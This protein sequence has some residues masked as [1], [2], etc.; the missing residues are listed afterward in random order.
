MRPHNRPQ[1]W[2]C[3][4]RV[5]VS[6]G[7]CRQPSPHNSRTPVDDNGGGATRGRVR[8][9]L[10][11][12]HPIAGDGLP[13]GGRRPVR[14]SPR[15]ARCARLR[16]AD[17]RDAGSAPGPPRADGRCPASSLPGRR[18]LFL[19][20]F[21]RTL[22]QI[23]QTLPQIVHNVRELID[24]GIE[25]ASLKQAID[26]ST[27][28][29]RV[30]VYIF[31]M[32]AEIERDMIGH[33]VK[34]GLAATRAKGTVLGRPPKAVDL[35]ALAGLLAARRPGA[36]RPRGCGPRAGSPR[37]SGTWRGRRSAR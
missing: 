26:L 9:L 24:L 1:D 20:R 25:F 4:A 13:T 27:M 32:L 5:L 33:R 16:G 21:G 3:R 12:Q 34:A 19:D 31:G 22:P 2:G 23:V 37:R 36:D 8:H 17:E 7:I 6:V 30:T 35:G 18:S 10:P 28:H 29:G 15:V 14:H 11:R